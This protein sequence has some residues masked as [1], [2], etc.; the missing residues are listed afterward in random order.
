[1]QKDEVELQAETIKEANRINGFQLFSMTTSMVMTVYGFAAFAKQGP[2]AL[3][4]LFLAGILW[5]IPVTKAAGEMASIDGWSKGGI[6][7][8]ARNML[9][10]K[11]GWA[12]LFY[13]WI[14]IT[15]GMNTMMYFIIGC[16]SISINLPIINNNPFVKFGLMMIILWGLILIQQRG[17]KITGRIAQWC[18]TLGVIIPVFFLLGIFIIYL[19]QGNPML[20]NINFKTILPS[21]WSGDVLVGFVPFILAFAGAEGSAPHVKDLENPRVYPKVMLA[22]AICAIFSDIV[23][24]MAIAGTIPNNNIQLSTG[25]V[26]AYGALVQRFG[27]SVVFVEKLSGL[28]LAIGVLGEISSWVVGPNAGMF[29]AAKS[30]FLPPKF[31]KANKYGIETNVMILQGII[32]SIMG[33]LLTFGAGG[34]KANLSFQT[35]MSLT[36]ALY[37]LMYMLLFVSYLVLQIK[38]NDLERPYVASQSKI[39]RLIYGGLGFILSAFGFLVTFFPPKDMVPTAKRTYL[40]L[41]LVGFVLVFFVPFILYRYHKRWANELG[42]PSEETVAGSTYAADGDREIVKNKSH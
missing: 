29:E 8:W 41:L 15:V 40:I 23:G 2:T 32:V 17:T 36:V 13:Q 4:F 37:T 26:Y 20:I 19:A 9:G 35:A 25:I 22:L 11:T 31:S 38:H 7:T 6:F 24:S 3:F 28:L 33:A 5:F 27:I 10:E 39:M 30:G 16:L 42:L 1:M 12:A 34:N 14:H 18:F 21:S